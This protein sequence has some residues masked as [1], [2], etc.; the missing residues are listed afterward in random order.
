MMN[1]LQEVYR[2]Q[3]LIQGGLIMALLKQSQIEAILEGDILA[4]AGGELPLG[5]ATAPQVMVLRKDFDKARQIVMDWEA[6]ALEAQ[7]AESQP[8]WLCPKCS[9]EIEGHYE[10]CWNCQHIRTQC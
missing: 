2:A 6:T 10:I 4:S 9:E 5:W 1:D 8:M 3:N 7:Q